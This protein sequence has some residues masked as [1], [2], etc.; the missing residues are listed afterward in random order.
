MNMKNRNTNIYN[1]LKR[2]IFKYD[3]PI[4]SNIYLV[5]LDRYSRIKEYKIVKHEIIYDNRKCYY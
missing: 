5:N 2:T 3:K 1:D 4:D